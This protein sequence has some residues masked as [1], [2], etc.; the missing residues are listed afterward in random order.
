MFSEPLGPNSASE[1]NDAA[2]RWSQKA[3]LLWRVKR[4]QTYRD[5]SAAALAAYRSN[6]SGPAPVLPSGPEPDSPPEQRNDPIP[7]ADEA[8]DKQFTTVRPGGRVN[9]VVVHIGHFEALISMH[10]AGVGVEVLNATENR[11]QEALRPHDAV[12]RIEGN[13]FAVVFSQN[14]TDVAGTEVAM[15]ICRKFDQPVST[16]AGDVMMSITL[17][18][19]AVDASEARAIE[20]P[21]LLAQARAAVLEADR[22]GVMIAEFDPV[23]RE[24]ALQFY[25][26]EQLLRSALSD[27]NISVDYQPIVN[28]HSGEVVAVEALARWRDDEAGSVSPGVFIPVAERSGLINKLG[29][30]VL[31]SSIAQ[32]ARW[33]PQLPGTNPLLTVN[34]S[35]YQLLD[36]GLIPSIRN[37]LDEHGLSPGQLCLEITESVV[38]ANVAASMTI[39]GHLKDLGLV[40]AIDD[41]GTGYS[42]LSYLR[43]MPVDVL[44]IDRSFVHSVHNRD[45]RIITKVIIDLAHTLGMTTI[46]EGVESALQVEVLHALNCDMAQGYLLHAPV[47]GDSVSFDQI[48]FK[49]LAKGPVAPAIN[50]NLGW[51]LPH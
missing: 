5:A 44:K 16:S 42:S 15:R 10:G 28:L 39:L 20:A 34:I 22:K 19:A 33:Q 26:T 41:F 35:N 4:L 14:N 43:S 21:T 6:V 45:D 49:T 3:R 31:Q 51:S 7:G 24:N 25:E 18:I 13:G 47:S 32:H 37:L 27:N 50:E 8:I 29:Q 2:A 46:A 23:M 40:L 9:V 36:P 38:M 1:P 30:V 12:T 17:G 11:I 48:D